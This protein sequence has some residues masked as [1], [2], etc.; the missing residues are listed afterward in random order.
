MLL[1]PTKKSNTKRKLYSLQAKVKVNSIELPKSYAEKF[2]GSCYG[3]LITMD[4]NM[5]TTLFNPFKDGISI[6]L[7]P[8]DFTPEKPVGIHFEIQKAVIT[9]IVFY[10]SLVYVIR[11]YNNVLSFDANEGF[12]SPKCKTVVPEDLMLGHIHTEHILLNHLT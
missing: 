7:P 8:L 5:V 10:T 2:C 1:I 9:D 6:H 11:H 4:E 3:W 12:E